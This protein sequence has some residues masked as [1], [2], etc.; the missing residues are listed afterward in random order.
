[1]PLAATAPAASSARPRLLTL[2]TVLTPLAL[3]LSLFV[4]LFVARTEIDQGDVQRLF[5]VHVPSFFGGFIAFSATLVGG[6]AYLR[7]RNLKWDRLA[8][9]GVEVGLA[10]SLV[11]LLTGMFWAR[12]IWNTWWTWDPRLTS[13]AI[14]ILTYFAYL[15]LRAG[16]DNPDTRRRFAAIYGVLAFVTVVITLIITRIRPDTIHPVVI[17]PSIQTEAQGMFDVQA[18]EGVRLALYAGFIPW[19]I[20]IPVTLIWYRVRLEALAERASLLKAQLLERAS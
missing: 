17:G 14:M 13:E 11:N 8:I 2:L 4:G 6:I 19:A 18:T 3:L 10:L 1:M 9:A 20:L 12:P 5:Y 7:T 15:M 16:I